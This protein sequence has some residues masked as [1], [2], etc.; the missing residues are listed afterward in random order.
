MMRPRWPSA[1]LRWP[2]G[3]GILAL[4]LAL[5]AQQASASALPLTGAN[6]DPGGSAALS[7]TAPAAE[8]GE[9]RF[10]ISTPA[11]QAPVLA[12]GPGGA[13]WP[14]GAIALAGVVAALTLGFAAGRRRWRQRTAAGSGD[15]PPAPGMTF[16]AIVEAA[17]LAIIG[18][19]ANGVI[20]AWNAG[21]ERLLGYSAAER[22]GGSL[23]EV[24]PERHRAGA[25]ELLA[26]AL[27]GEAVAVERGVALRRDGR[28]VMVSIATFPVRDATGRVTGVGSVVGDTGPRVAAEREQAWLAAIVEASGDAIVSYAGDGTVLTWNRGAERLLGFTAEEVVGT[29][30]EQILPAEDGDSGSPATG[31]PESDGMTET[32]TVRVTKDGRRLDVA[33]TFLNMPGPGGRQVRVAILR[34]ISEKKRLERERAEAV[35]EALRLA[36]VVHSAND[37]I[38]IRDMSGVI[39]FVN[40]AFERLAGMPSAEV[41]GAQSLSLTTKEERERLASLA[42]SALGGEPYVTEFEAR[43]RNGRSLPVRLVSFPIRDTAGVQTGVAAI[44]HDLTEERRVGRE[45]IE[46]ARIAAHMAAIVESSDDAIMS[47]DLEGRILSWNPAAE[48]L[49]GYAAEEMVGQTPAILVPPELQE[50]TAGQVA[51]AFRGEVVHV[52]TERIAKDGHRITIALMLFPVVGASDEPPILAAI[53]RDIGPRKQAEMALRESE[54]RYRLLIDT[55][56][57]AV[58]VHQDGQIVFANRAGARL[59]G[60]N[61]PDELKGKA[62]WEVLHP[63]SRE[64][65]RARIDAMV[66]GTQG[67]YTVEDVYMRSDG[68]PVAVEVTAVPLV[69][70]GRP[71]IQ[72]VVLDI[73]ARKRAEE[74]RQRMEAQV[75][76]TQKLESLGVLAGGIAHDFNN[77]LTGIVGNAGMA[78]DELPAGSS[79]YEVVRDVE[80]AGLRAAELTR[81]LLAYAGKARFSVGPVDLSVL[82]SE[83]A[84]LLEVSISKKARLVFRSDPG[85]P[86]IEGDATQL[87]QVVMNLITNASDAI[88]ENPGTIT[89]TTGAME[90]TREDLLRSYVDGDLPPG[91]YVY[92]EVADT[93]S[94][95][96][97][98]TVDRI[99]EP[100]FTTKFTGRGL[101]M[102]AVLGIIRSHR[103]AIIVTSEPG[104]GSTFRVL[105][106]ASA[107]VAAPAPGPEARVQVT[108]ATSR[109]LVVDDDEAVRKLTARVLE[110]AGAT[111]TVARDGHEAVRLF[112]A[113]HGGFDVVVL[114]LTMP[115]MD[116][117]ETF[118]VLRAI[119][120][121]V[122]VVLSSGYGEEE[123]LARLEGTGAAGFIQK[124]YRPSELLALV[125]KV[126]QG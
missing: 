50:E 116:G 108:L 77:L 47:R 13:L 16:D 17:G 95:M 111:V 1:A 24:P 10:G 38:L 56:P 27:Q 6:D 19:D 109:A 78:L 125:Q 29:R 84:H 67:S 36:E 121:K 101:G 44:F 86:A 46:A 92:V 98:A 100:F 52:E 49:F 68:T 61:S 102:A 25:R 72:V 113:G 70:E 69:Y 71:A 3:A 91:Q 117:A 40:A 53:A 35:N 87:R 26:R 83:M 23:F 65:A 5:G 15:G 118:R 75:Q 34:D 57:Y 21:A 99:F 33:A 66:A 119:D 12:G 82:V 115:G 4:G 14:E 120:A 58:A 103:G 88:G 11:R 30:A 81:Q 123:A 43:L 54:E 62:I 106:P 55:S 124:P 41:V 94:G 63:D 122:R 126:L 85:L 80:A 73:T 112:R 2:A 51:R 39:T 32:E 9:I 97:Q 20:T 28:E 76:H 8:P 93:G 31:A 42:A 114:D 90:A 48:R 89:V 110:G 74:E 79:A 60:A 96:D 22:L 7:R 107:A 18:A 45:R 37:A 105:I 64:A 104:K 59:V